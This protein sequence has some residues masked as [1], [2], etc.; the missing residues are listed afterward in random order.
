VEEQH[1][2]WLPLWQQHFQGDKLLSAN[3]GDAREIAAV[4]CHI[5]SRQKRYQDA[6]NLITAF[7]HHPQFS[8]VRPSDLAIL[9][10]EQMFCLLRIGRE[11]DAATIG[12]QI[13]QLGPETERWQHINLLCATLLG[14]VGC[15]KSQRGGEEIATEEFTRLVIDTLHCV[16][17]Q[18]LPDSLPARATYEQLIPLVCRTGQKLTAY[19]ENTTGIRQAEFSRRMRH[20]LRCHCGQRLTRCDLSTQQV[21]DLRFHDETHIHLAF[22]CHLCQK[23][24]EFFIRQEEWDERLLDEVSPLDE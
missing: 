1:R 5:A 6:L 8:E 11:T 9:Y 18:S 19:R 3:L 15:N 21:L 20:G 22:H 14:Q 10:I 7:Y 13:L 23:K 12:H 16:D 24:S 2:R 4:G 17:P